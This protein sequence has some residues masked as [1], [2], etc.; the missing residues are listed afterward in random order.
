MTFFFSSIDFI[1]ERKFGPSF[2]HS[3]IAPGV[4]MVKRNKFRQKDFNNI[5]HHF[6]I[7]LGLQFLYPI[8]RDLISPFGYWDRIVEFYDYFR[9]SH[10]LNFIDSGFQL[11]SYLALG[12]ILFF[13]IRKD[14]NTI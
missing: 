9:E 1:V 5:W 4:E 7:G 2:G 3:R 14:Q 13:S 8:G 6:F 12:I 10:W 11:L